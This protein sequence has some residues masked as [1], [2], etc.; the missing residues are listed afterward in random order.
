[1]NTRFMEELPKHLSELDLAGSE[2]DEMEDNI[3]EDYEVSGVS[4]WRP[5]HWSLDPA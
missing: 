2:D 4:W 5:Q 3:P 1:M